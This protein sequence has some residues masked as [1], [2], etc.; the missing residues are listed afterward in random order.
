MQILLFFNDVYLDL[1]QGKLVDIFFQDNFIYNCF[2]FCW[3]L[4]DN[5][6]VWVDLWIWVFYGSFV[7]ASFGYGDQVDDVNN[8]YFD[9]FYV[10]FN[11]W[12]WVM[13]IMLDCLYM[14]YV[15]DKLEV[16]LG[17]QCINWGISMVWNFNDIFNVFV[18]IDFDYEEWL[19]SDV[20]W[21]KYYIGFVLSVE[22]AVGMFDDIDEVMMAGFWWFNKWFYDFQVLVGYIWGDWV[23]G[24]GWAGN[25]GNVGLKGEFICF[26]LVE[27][28]DED[29]VFVV[30]LGLD[31]FFF[32]FLYVSLG[33]LYNSE[34]G[35]CNSIIGFF[36]FEFLACNLYF[37]WYVFFV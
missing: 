10:I 26:L 3:Y 4:D 15:N 20:F 14:E 18:F 33:Y 35:I 7:Q 24:G 21:V 31:Y 28:L 9:L 32:N 23:L 29:L 12:A 6:M 1:L 25:L 2:N 30:M 22:L 8:D 19:G 36:V 13:Y 5:W 27:D 16:W 37:Y 34:G 11:E 17:W